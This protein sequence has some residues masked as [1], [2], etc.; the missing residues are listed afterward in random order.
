VSVLLLQ[1]VEV[2]FVP[3]GKTLAREG[4]VPSQLIILRS[5]TV[6]VT[7]ATMPRE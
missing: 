1:L 7:G 5:G 6:K 4:T 3:P 2:E